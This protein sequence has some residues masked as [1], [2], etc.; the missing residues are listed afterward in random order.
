MSRDEDGGMKTEQGR[1]FKPY[2]AYKDSGV[3][4]LGKIPAHWTV[5]ALKRIGS[6]QA[7]A[8]FPDDKQGLFDEEV[9]FFKVGDM[10]MPGNEREMLMHQ[11]SVSRS[12][13]RQLRAFVFP[14]STITFAKV[15][16][17]LL[18]NRRRLLV[19]PS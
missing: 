14:P 12:T 8:G 1:R 7:G 4:W 9:P 5:T 18:L 6:L 17:A 3:E 19:R 2:P 13:A 16:A 15:G 10:G 11:H